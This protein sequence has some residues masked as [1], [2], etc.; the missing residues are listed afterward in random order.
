MW[1]LNTDI[2][3]LYAISIIIILLGAFLV[4]G[5]PEYY[6]LA[7]PLLLL[8]IGLFLVSVENVYFL[9]A[10]CTPISIK[11]MIGSSGIN[12]PN[13]PLMLVFLLLSIIKVAKD[14]GTIRSIL[15]HQITILILINLSW[16]F[17]TSV[18]ST[19]PIISFK[20]L[21][22]RI[23]TVA[24]GFFW[25][26][27]IFRKP[28]NI[29]SFFTAFGL[30]L[31]I[32]IIY[33]TINHA[34]TGFSQEKSML[35]MHP[36]MDDHTVYSAVCS[37][38]FI[39][40]LVLLTFKNGGL[41]YWYKMLIF[42][43]L[44]LCTVGIILSYSRAAVLSLIFALGFNLLLKGKVKFKSV[45]IALFLF[46]TLALTFSN[47]IYQSIKYNKA[48]SGKNLATD[49]RS[50][51]NVK[52]DVSNVERINRWESGYR[53]FLEKPFF[54]YGPG[55]Y[56][57]E[58]SPYQRAH[59]MTIISTTH[60]TMGEIHSEYFGPLVESGVIGLLIII[61]LFLTYISTLMR[62]YYHPQSREIKMLAL[63]ILLAMLSYF[64][65]GLMNNFLDQDKIAVIFWA[66]MGMAVAL[67]FCNKALLE[68]T[69]DTNYTRMLSV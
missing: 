13:E 1:H 29:K 23:W 48:V 20:F 46:L 34:A 49:I 57:F 28:K 62:I 5:F 25:G 15:K 24:F 51:S 56:M 37:I 39:Y 7:L 8:I 68:E 35:V 40:A 69:K 3:K 63:A 53:M 30:G 54:G 26:T 4:V 33:T 66:M 11:L 50:V 17:I 9:V 32:V 27:I 44:A 67:D 12:I 65:H 58:Y 6:I 59:E 61:G 21:L 52:T 45:L 60:G 43:F 18:T 36:L 16:I 42:L 38:V 14:F 31:C 2:K 22:A 10:F 47:Q 64:F 41:V 19:L 55:T